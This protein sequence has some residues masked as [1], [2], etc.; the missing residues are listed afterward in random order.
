MTGEYVRRVFQL[1]YNLRQDTDAHLHQGI[2]LRSIGK[3]CRLGAQISFEILTLLGIF[4]R[5]KILL[6]VVS[7]QRVG[8]I[9][10]PNE[11]N[12]LGRGFINLAIRPKRLSDLGL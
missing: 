4:L 5:Q 9:R 12:D 6:K 7:Q 2:P 1:D 8:P 10:L 11:T 3:E